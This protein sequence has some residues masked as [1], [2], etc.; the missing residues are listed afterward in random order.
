MFDELLA[1]PGV[2]EVLDLKSTFGFMAFHG[3]NLERVT[4][5]IASEA[6]ARSGASFYGV[7]QPSHMRHH[8]P[9]KEVQPSASAK[10]AAFLDHVDVAVAIHGYGRRERKTELLVG[11]RNRDLAGHVSGHLRDALPAYQIIDELDEI[12]R[13]LRGVHELNPVNLARGGGV[14]LELPPRVR[15]LSPLWRY[16]KVPG[17]VP[18]LEDLIA[19]LAATARTWDRPTLD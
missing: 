11:G 12:P 2:V 3:G 17:R 15:G 13:E 10:L 18:H 9:S 14:Q 19:A 16:W 5:V 6:A 8:I 1:T 7:I 4:E